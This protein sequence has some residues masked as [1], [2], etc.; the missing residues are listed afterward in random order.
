M[1]KYKKKFVKI[2][3]RSKFPIKNKNLKKIIII[4][5]TDQK[6]IFINRIPKPTFLQILIIISQLLPYQLPIPITQSF[7]FSIDFSF[8]RRKN[9][10]THRF[11]AEYHPKTIQYEFNTKCCKCWTQKENQKAIKIN[12][13]SGNSAKLTILQEHFGACFFLV[14]EQNVQK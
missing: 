12:F 10:K 13:H 7:Q 14:A 3:I 11:F 9:I 4:A 2:E 1:R 6:P 8:Q 5:E